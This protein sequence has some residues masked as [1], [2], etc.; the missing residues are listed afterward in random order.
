MSRWSLPRYVVRSPSERVRQE[1]IRRMAIAEKP[2]PT[3][4][5][6]DVGDPDGVHGYQV[7]GRLDEERGFFAV[8]YDDKVPDGLYRLERK[9]SRNPFLY[10][11]VVSGKPTQTFV[12]PSVAILAHHQRGR[13]SLFLHHDGILQAMRARVLLPSSWARWISDRVL[14]NAAPGFS[15]GAWRYRVRHRRVV[16]RRH[17]PPRPR[18]GAR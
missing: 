11:S 9:E 18:R 17:H 3:Q 6:S 4:A 15:E 16:A 1:F 5:V 7:I 8:R 2:I 13:G 12:S 10:R 14:C